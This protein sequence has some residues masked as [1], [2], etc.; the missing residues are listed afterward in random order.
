MKL[1]KIVTS[2]TA[3]VVVS[4]AITVSAGAYSSTVAGV[5]V[6]YSSSINATYALSTSSIGA[7]PTVNDLEARISADYVYRNTSTGISEGDFKITG[8][9]SGGCGVQYKAPNGCEMVSVSAVHWFNV[10]GTEKSF[11]SAASR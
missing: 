7:D 5:T 6:N 1:R 11:R 10:N 8:W 3:M 4:A 2:V 9:N